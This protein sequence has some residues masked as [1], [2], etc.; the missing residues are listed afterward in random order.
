MD[1]FGF[2]KAL[3]EIK[4]WPLSDI[5]LFGYNDAFSLAFNLNSYALNIINSFDSQRLQVINTFLYFYQDVIPSLYRDKMFEMLDNC[6]VSFYHILSLFINNDL[7]SRDD[8]LDIFDMFFDEREELNIK[9]GSLVANNSN[10]LKRKD[11]YSIISLVLNAKEDYQVKN[12]YRVAS[13]VDVL[14]KYDAIDYVYVTSKALGRHQAECA[15][16]YATSPLILNRDDGVCFVKLFS[17]CRDVFEIYYLDKILSD[18][19]LWEKEDP[20]FIV[21]L[22]YSIFSD[23]RDTKEYSSWINYNSIDLLVD[24]LVTLNYDS[25]KNIR[26]K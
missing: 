1:R 3:K 7:K 17:Y 25:L 19:R 21:G 14:E 2:V 5:R 15:S 16:E 23:L 10:V 12:A 9:Y 26:I 24:D 6:D 4:K 18:D 13:D 20:L 22:G 11:A 8:H